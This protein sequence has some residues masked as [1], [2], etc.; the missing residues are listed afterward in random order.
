MLYCP[1]LFHFEGALQKDLSVHLCGIQGWHISLSDLNF[2]HTREIY[3]L[4]K[5]TKSYFNS[6]TQRK[7][8]VFC[9]QGM[10]S[11]P[12]NT[13]HFTVLQSQS[14]EIKNMTSC[15]STSQTSLQPVKT[16][17]ISW[18]AF[19]CILEMGMQSRITSLQGS[20]GIRQ[21]LHGFFLHSSW[22]EL[23]CRAESQVLHRGCLQFKK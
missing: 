8:Y 3:F 22:A 7:L 13:K 18:T 17:P 15:T 21:P 11:L 23:R 4:S 14:T 10:C 12:L 2:V 19:L 20:Q 9:S 6:T 1:Y 5:S 16:G